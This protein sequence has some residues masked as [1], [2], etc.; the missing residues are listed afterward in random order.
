MLYEPWEAFS[1]DGDDRWGADV[2]VTGE[3]YVL[4]NLLEVLL[5]ARGARESM[6]AA[7]TRA[8]DGGLLDDIPGLLYARGPADGVAEEL[9][10][11]GIQRLVG[12]LDELPSPVL[13]YRLLEPPS[14]KATLA[15]RALDLDKVHRRSP[16]A[17]V[18][19]T[20]GC[21]FRC[22]YCPIPAYNQHQFRTRSGERI[23]ERQ[24]AAST[25][26]G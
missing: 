10:D 15:S 23:A 18:V 6:R 8:R 11:T 4:L 16:I 25:H 21:K 12:N 3:E 14:R 2:A 9:V 17:A 24:R 22:P 1:T 19:L 13:G 20:L 5:S 7:F 26:C